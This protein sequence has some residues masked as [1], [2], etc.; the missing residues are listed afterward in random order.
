[1]T[2]GTLPIRHLGLRA[3]VHARL[4]PSR[5][6]ARAAQESRQ[7]ALEQG[8]LLP[9]ENEGR[10]RHAVRHKKTRRYPEA[11]V[12]HQGRP[13]PLLPLRG[14]CRPARE[15]HPH[16]CLVRHHRQ[17]HRGR[18]HAQGHG[19]LDERRR[20]V[21]GRRRADLERHRAHRVLVRPVHRRLRAPLRRR[22]GSAPRSSRSRP[23]A[24]NAR[25]RS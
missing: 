20:A 24:A 15:G 17:V 3:R 25:S 9:A 21:P 2:T 11:P 5:A 23:A 6:S 7:D 18:L 8:S 4:G 12:H 14:L 1:M 22:D 16:P 13:A 10:R 19:D